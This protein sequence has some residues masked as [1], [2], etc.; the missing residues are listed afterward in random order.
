MP[1]GTRGQFIHFQ[2]QAVAPAALREM[3]ESTGACDS[4]TDDHDPGMRL[5]RATTCMPSL[6]TQSP[7]GGGAPRRAPLTAH[8]SRRDVF[9]ATSV[10]APLPFPRGQ[11]RIHHLLVRLFLNRQTH[12]PVCTAQIPAGCSRHHPGAFSRSSSLLGR[13][14]C[15]RHIP[16]WYKLLSFRSGSP[17]TEPPSTSYGPGP[18]R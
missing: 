3:I 2:Q 13:S 8:A 14:I 15:T 5:H 10:I 11:L 18:H 12:N 17:G 9:R 1:G 6:R 7:S 16:A 4:P